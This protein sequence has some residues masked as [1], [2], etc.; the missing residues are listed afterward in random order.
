M[1]K[2]V[3]FFTDLHVGSIHSVTFDEVYL[4]SKVPHESNWIRPKLEQEG[5]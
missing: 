4:E 2:K 5:A 1:S 3:A